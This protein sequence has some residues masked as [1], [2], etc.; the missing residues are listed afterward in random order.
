MDDLPPIRL[1]KD[2][3]HLIQDRINQMEA[4]YRNSDMARVV[5]EAS[6]VKNTAKDEPNAPRIQVINNIDDEAAPP[7]EFH[8]SNGIFL[9]EGVPLPDYSK[10][11]GCGCR[12][13]CDPKSKTCLCVQRQKKH[14]P[15]P[16][17]GFFYDKSGRLKDCAE[18][19]P[20]FECNALCECTDECTNK[21]SLRSSQL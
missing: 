5:L 13:R 10:L 14:Y 2:I 8:Y 21:V 6:I 17:G 4:I 3:P 9:G 20:I 1:T 19:Y 11:R 12:G 7:W 15:T 16:E 18:G